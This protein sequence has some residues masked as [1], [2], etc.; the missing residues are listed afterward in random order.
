MLTSGAHQWPDGRR[1]HHASYGEIGGIRESIIVA[2][3]L[4]TSSQSLVD[5][6]IESQRRS[7]GQRSY[8]VL[9][10]KDQAR[11]MNALTAKRCKDDPPCQ[12]AGSRLTA[13][14]GSSL[15]GCRNKNQPHLVTRARRLLAILSY[16]TCLSRPSPKTHVASRSFNG[17]DDAKSGVLRTLWICR[18]TNL[19]SACR[20]GSERPSSHSSHLPSPM[21]RIIRKLN[22]A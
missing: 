21:T 22:N 12:R 3:E 10:V 15:C 17:Q 14:L 9:I 6:S 8:V 18:C 11:H 19:Q 13:C 2:C 16:Q 20:K 1:F 7:L 4:C 5:R